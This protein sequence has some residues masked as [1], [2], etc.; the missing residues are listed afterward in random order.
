MG[1]PVTLAFA[2]EFPGVVGFDIDANKIAR[3]RAHEDPTRTAQSSELAASSVRF[4]HEESDLA[5]ASFFVVAVPTPIDH[6]RRPDLSM[7]RS[8]SEI[9]GRALSPGAVVVYESTVYPGLTEE[10][11]GPILEA[12]SGLRRGVDFTLG[13]SPE[14]INPGD[15]EH[16][17]KRIVKVVAGEDEAT[18]ERVANVYGQII[19][20]GVHR[21]SSIKVAEAAKVI[22]NT[23]RDLNIALMNELAMIFDR[24][25]INTAEVLEAAGTKW[26]FLRFSPGLVGGHCIGVDPYYLTSKAEELG[27]IPQVI[28]AGR[29]INDGMGAFV[30]KKTIK[31]LANRNGA[32]KDA[33]VA[34]L[35]L[36]FKENVPDI[37]NSR[38]PDILAELADYGVRAQVHDP[39]VDPGEAKRA[40]GVDLVDW[41]DLTDLDA[42]IVAVPHDVYHQELPAR[43]PTMLKQ[44]GV[45][46]DVKSL[47]RSSEL[48]PGL[49]HWSL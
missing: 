24:L 6:A 41:A 7:L 14:R 20:A 27:Y 15:T 18:L 8:A 1:L 43:L 34:V 17:L 2:E 30:A 13:Y 16:T 11:C 9:V 3:L 28:L 33:K 32:L 29:R 31:M 4:S 10:I 42:L 23:Q 26:N 5:G 40:Y 44:D 39:L 37:R 35:G 47:F 25:D 49:T 19:D 48:P 46:I 38:I 12:T 22:E 45:L 36:S 21:A